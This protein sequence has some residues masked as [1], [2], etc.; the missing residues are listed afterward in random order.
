MKKTIEN[1]IFLKLQKLSIYLI[2][3]TIL[4][5]FANYLYVK[6]NT[7]ISFQDVEN[8]KDYAYIDIYKMSEKFAYN[9]ENNIGIHYIIDKEETGLWHTYLIAINESN[10]DNYKEI[11]D[12][13]YNRTDKVPKSIRVYGYPV[14][15]NNELKEMAIKNIEKFVPAQN[16]IKITEENY[17]TYLTNSYLDTTKSINRNI[18]FTFILIII[19]LFSFIGLFILTIFEKET[20]KIKKT[21]KGRKK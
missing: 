6:Q 3:I 7:S 2:I 5:V 12:Y 10:Y 21:K 1:K 18:N 4:S 14:L 9:E 15:V 19:L 13:T 20:Q 16:E 8:T 11:I 17:E